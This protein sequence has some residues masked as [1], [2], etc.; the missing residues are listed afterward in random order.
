MNLLKKSYSWW[1]KEILNLIAFIQSRLIRLNENPLNLEMLKSGKFLILAPHSDDEWVGCSRI[2]I[3]KKFEV[4][5]CNMNMPGGDSK[6]LHFVRHNEMSIM[7]KRYDRL[8]TTISGDCDE[9]VIQLYRFIKTFNPNYIC[10]PCV[11]DWHEDHLEVINILKRIVNTYLD[12][13]I[14]CKILMYQVSVP[15][16][17]KQLTHNLKMNYYEQLEKWKLFKDTYKTQSQ[18]PYRRF[19]KNE[20]I[21]GCYCN[22]YAA[23]VF[24]CKSLSDWV[25]YVDIIIGSGI[26]KNLFKMINNLVRIRRYINS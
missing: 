11:V 21:S 16:P 15:I 25:K 14:S 2:L 3:N 18:F 20:Y 17:R 10:V 23:E 4:V 8:L 24:S 5:I 1:Y 9:K 6:E 12:I 13:D 26:N 19:M 22:S 7:A